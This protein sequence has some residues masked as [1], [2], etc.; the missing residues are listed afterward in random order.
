[1]AAKDARTLLVRAFFCVVRP[2]QLIARVGG[3]DI[4]LAVCRDCEGNMLGLMSESP[5]V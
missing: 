3:K 1:M 4:H 2:A 5:T